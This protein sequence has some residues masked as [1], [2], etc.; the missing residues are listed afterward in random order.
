MTRTN[1]RPMVEYGL[2]D[3][4]RNPR[5]GSAGS[6]F[7]VRSSGAAMRGPSLSRKLQ[8][9]ERLL[10]VPNPSSSEQ[11]A[12]RYSN[13]DLAELSV[14]EL[15]IQEVFAMLGEGL[16]E[17]PRR[18]EWWRNRRRTAKALR[19]AAAQPAGQAVRAAS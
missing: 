2:D 17:D 9:L 6:G 5:S 14:E 18:A 3:A 7:G 11:E 8:R 16:D 12:N 4:R 1:S 10:T 13:A 19:S 15:A